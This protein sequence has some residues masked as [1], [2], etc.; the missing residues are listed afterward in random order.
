M[1]PVIL[2]I[3]AIYRI[4]SA[5]GPWGKSRC[6]CL[7]DTSFEN[8]AKIQSQQSET[9]SKQTRV[10]WGANRT[11]KV[12]HCHKDKTLFR[13]QKA[14]TDKF[15]LG[16]KAT[17]YLIDALQSVLSLSLFQKNAI[18]WEHAL[19]SY[20]CIYSIV[21]AGQVWQEVSH[22]DTGSGVMTQYKQYTVD[23]HTFI[24]LHFTEMSSYT[25]RTLR[26]H[27]KEKHIGWHRIG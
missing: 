7:S 14:K 8:K 11:S 23:P 26:E 21:R 13:K 25:M 2:F 24:L 22:L 1:F 27:I 10:D 4:F 12:I 16:I 5:S 15:S 17:W 9:W 6:I 19:I 3:A 20:T 18:N